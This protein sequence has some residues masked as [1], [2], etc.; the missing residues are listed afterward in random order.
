MGRKESNQTN[1]SNKVNFWFSNIYSKKQVKH[2]L[3]WNKIWIQ[4]WL[5][6][7]Y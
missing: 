7:Q 3:L 4:G 1:K 2:D 5:L 6:S